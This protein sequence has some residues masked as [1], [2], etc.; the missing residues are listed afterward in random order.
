MSNSKKLSKQN[1]INTI[2]NIEEFLSN[3][4]KLLKINED[5]ML[6]AVMN[7]KISKSYYNAWLQEVNSV[8]PL[9]VYL[10]Q[11]LKKYQNQNNS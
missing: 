8:F 1:N 11:R 3:T 4:N 9:R 6:T 7:K 5:L 2:K 10:S